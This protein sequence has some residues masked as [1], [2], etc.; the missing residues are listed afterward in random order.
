M[1]KEGSL[2]EIGEIRE[3]GSEGYSNDWRIFWW[4]LQVY[5]ETGGEKL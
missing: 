2:G 3:K 5:D 1:C 4:L